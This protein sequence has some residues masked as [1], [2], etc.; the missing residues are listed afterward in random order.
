MTDRMRRLL[1][2]TALSLSLAAPLATTALAAEAARPWM[3]TKLSPDQRADLLNKELTLDERI[4]LVHGP[5]AMPFL[6]AKLPEGAIGSAGYIPGVPRLGIPALQESD[7]SLGVANPMNVRPGDPSTALPSGLS[8]A[9]TWNPETAY[10][11]GAMIGKEAHA[12]GLNV[13]LAGGVN[14]ARDPRNGRNFEYLGED[15]LLA[16]TLG[17]ESIRG[18]QDQNVVST[19]KHFAVNDQETQRMTIDVKIGEAAA[20]ESDL[21]AF[22]I[23][24]EKG[25]PGSVMCAYNK[26]NGAYACDNPFLL[27]KVLKTDWAYPG[28]VMSDWGAVHGVEAAVNGLDQESGEQIDALLAPGGA[29][30]VWFNEPLKAAIQDKTVPAERL[31]DM[32]RRILR[33][34]FAAGLF[35]NPAAK[36]PIDFDAHAQVTKAAGTEGIVLLKNKGDVLP[37]ATKGKTITVIGGFA[38]AGVLSGGGSSQVV[39]DGGPG[40]SIPL[41]G[42]G[43]MGPFRTVVYHASSP[44]KAIRAKAGEKAVRFN[45]GSYPAEAAA[46]AKTTNV[47]IVFA[48]QWMS[49]GA[50]APDL[51][52]PNGQDALIAA[53]A[54]ANPNTIVVLE[55]GGPVHMPWL[56]KVAGVVEAWY[57]GS[58]GGEAIADILF[59]DA[60]P[61][62]RLPITF[63]ADDSQLLHKD[64]PGADKPEFSPAEITY[65]EGA[66]IGYR[67]Y[68]K[69]G[70]KP[71]FPFGYGLSYSHFSYGDVKVTGG[72]TLTVSFEVTNTG[73][74]P[75]QDVPQVYLTNAAGTKTQR[76]IG[77]SK[78][79]LAPGEKKRVTVTADTRL[80]GS[81]DEAAHAWQ[82]KAGEYQVAVGAS[83]TDLD[84]KGGAAVKASTR[85][86]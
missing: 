36:A 72:D 42:D 9:S 50:D 40:A 28:W 30:K 24:I 14:L 45:D 10:K 59:G 57:P 13:L 77:W 53:V 11:G 82:V 33:S 4:G 16:G 47:A 37:L 86:P 85:Q 84:L 8:L 56:D 20:R 73:K 51:S 55:T 41:G 7:A 12:K 18:I 80:L 44:L 81:F 48:T 83:A 74:R 22:Q 38:N 23:A 75:G 29:G 61:S 2:G 69:T 32:T 31:S 76:L 79:A 63:P 60:N 70:A 54:A 17:G 62:G 67:R 19:I 43:M 52:L 39:S 58:R 64:I 46:V 34:M 27:N 68:A 65:T 71:L 1:L 35:D 78:V 49:E 6:G 21:L 3:D 66:D 5:M 26:V 25:K 15:P